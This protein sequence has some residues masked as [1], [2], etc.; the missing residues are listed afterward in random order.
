MKTAIQLLLNFV[1]NA[2][3][4][5]CLIALLALVAD[6]ITW[7][8]TRIR[9]AVWVVALIAAIFLP[10]FSAVATFRSSSIPAAV[11]TNQRTEF[12]PVLTTNSAEEVSK[13]VAAP[14]FHVGSIT[15]VAILSLAALLIVYRGSK[16]FR[17]LRYMRRL[18][19]TVSEFV[20]GSAL[21]DVLERCRRVFDVENTRV[22]QSAL[23]KTP[24]TIG[25]FQ[26]LV[27]LPP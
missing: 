24:S 1:V 4:Q 22:V 9:H 20:P 3:W 14:P 7:S 17:A 11:K 13:P 15:A 6:R 25:V 2:A 23:V 16:L 19:K 26:P 27:I 5:V 12:I 8:V 18:K 10:V 21:R